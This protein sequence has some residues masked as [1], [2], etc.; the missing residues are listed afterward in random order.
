MMDED[1][2]WVKQ[3]LPDIPAA[4]YVVD[5][6][7]AEY[8]PPKNKGHEVM[9]YLTYIIDHYDRLSDVTLFMHSHRWAYHNNELQGADAV[10]MVRALGHTR[11]LREGYMNLRCSWD[12]GCPAHLRPLAKELDFHH[13]QPIMAEQWPAIF[14]SS[15]S[16]SSSV[17]QKQEQQ[18]SNQQQQQPQKQGQEIP[19]VL[20]QP[21]CSQF[22]VS[23][24]RIRATSRKQYVRYRD[25]LLRTPV[26]D[27]YSG[28]LWEYLW[29]FLFTG[30]GVL[31]P[32]AHVCYC[33]GYGQ[34]YGGEKQLAEVDELYLQRAEV[35]Q[36]LE[37][38]E[39][40]GN[41]HG[42]E[43]GEADDMYDGHAGGNQ[44]AATTAKLDPRRQEYLREKRDALTHELDVRT[45]E[46]KERGKDPRN[47][48]AEAGRAWHEDDGF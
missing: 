5:D 24:R 11:V 29:Q 6:P 39:K 33:D 9:V 41:Q 36:E 21:C 28:R 35:Q 12:P 19:K 37:Q 34:C 7:S 14:S 44:S 31:C 40:E 4:I 38:I 27:Y 48:A 15:S 17:G 1:T 45:A 3:K 10:Q 26:T 43:S 30:Q 23:R 13:M 22:A 46:A 2:S 16:D 32:K 8:H 47:R 20:A 18:R 25:W 42:E